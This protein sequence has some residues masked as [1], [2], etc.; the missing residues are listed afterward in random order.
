MNNITENQYTP[1]YVSPPGET[2]LEILESRGMSQTE[3]AIRTGRT[4]KHINSIIKEKS[5]ITQEMA[6][7][8]ER[9]LDVPSSFWNNREQQYQE[10]LARKNE[11]KNL[12]KDITW[13]KKFPIKAM[14]AMGWIH[15]CRNQI[16]Q[17]KEVIKFFGVAAP[18][19]WEDWWNYSQQAAFRE[20][21]TFQS[22]PG[23][24]AAWLRKGTLEAQN[25]SCAPYNA[26]DFRNALQKI[27]L[28]TIEPPEIFQPKMVNL[29]AAAG[30][31]VV[32]VPELPK[33]RI[34]GAT[35]WLTHNKALIQLSL[36]YKKDDHFW[37]TFFHE[38]GH[39]LKHGK[40]DVFLED[41]KP[42]DN[43]KEK[44]A[45]KFAADILIPPAKYRYFL[46]LN[47][48]KY[49]SKKAIKEFAFEIEVSP[50]IIVGRLQHDEIIP[51]SNCNGLKQTFVWSN[52]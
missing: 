49:M 48:N 51:H 50:G 17:I 13:L 1:D 9:V 23:A 41:E 22:D 18:T 27:R 10:S 6:L 33:L 35:K 16:E 4:K 46:S 47:R 40:T 12:K 32:F 43:K 30:V 31:A 24:V 2:L 36:R 44:E 25:I 5:P 14:V 38:A 37:F 52:N 34:S 21:P 11:Q 45:N 26:N 28:L 19:Q 29:C 42:D 8:L 15:S 20:S 7:Q 3:L 39:I